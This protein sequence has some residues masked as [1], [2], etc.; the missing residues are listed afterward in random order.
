MPGA[1]RRAVE[2]LGDLASLRLPE[3][4]GS[5]RLHTVALAVGDDPFAGESD[6]EAA[7]GAYA[8][9]RH[10]GRAAAPNSAICL[11]RF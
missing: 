9:E 6:V 3:Q 5:D 10:F 2:P 11:Y 8:G 1:T 7:D 4:Q